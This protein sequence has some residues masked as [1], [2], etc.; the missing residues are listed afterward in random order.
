MIEELNRNHRIIV[1]WQTYLYNLYYLLFYYK[2]MFL[3]YLI[4][5]TVILIRIKGEI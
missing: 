5:Y 1:E 2:V 3:L 4:L